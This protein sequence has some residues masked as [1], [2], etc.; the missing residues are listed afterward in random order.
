LLFKKTEMCGSWW[1][2]RITW[3]RLK[4]FRSERGWRRR[5]NGL[6]AGAGGVRVEAG[7]KTLPGNGKTSGLTLIEVLVVIALV[8]IIFA[9]LLPAHVGGGKSPLFTCMNHLKEIDLGLILYAD[10][11]SGNFPMRVPATNAGATAFIYSRYA[12]PAL[13]K[14][15]AY[16]I[17]PANLVCPLD[18]TGKRQP[19]FKP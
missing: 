1:S 8:V 3:L 18:K 5:K 19:I 14:L 9:L 12:F 7:M 4:R 17:H 16:S 11:F 6:V 15:S 2:F 10:D 13:K